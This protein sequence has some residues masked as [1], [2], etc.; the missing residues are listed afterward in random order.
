MAVLSKQE[1]TD[2][3]GSKFA[4]NTIQDITEAVL[5]E[6]RQDIADSFADVSAL[7][8][9]TAPDY[10]A[11]AIYGR[12]SLV[13]FGLPKR[14]YQ[15]K[16]PGLLPA[17]T[18]GQ[19]TT[20]WLPVAAP[21]SPLLPYRE[22]PVRQ[23]QDYSS[24]GLL[25]PSK[26]YRFT[27]RVDANGDALDDVLVVALSRHKVNEADA[28]TIGIDP[29]TRQEYLVPVAYEL[30]TDTTAPRA[31]GGYTEAQ[32]DDLLNT[33]GSAQVQAQHTQLLTTLAARAANLYAH[34]ADNTVAPFADLDSFL[35]AAGLHGGTLRL[36]G[37]ATSLYISANNRGGWP[38]Y[39]DAAG[40]TIVVPDR[41]TLR[42]S[43]AG[44][45]NLSFAN[46]YLAG[47]AN[48]TGIFNLTGQLPQTTSAGQASLLFNGQS[49]ITVNNDNNVVVLDG[50]TYKKI[51]G[52]GKYYLLGSVEV[53]DQ[54]EASNV[55]DLRG[56]TGGGGTGTVKTVNGV[57]PDAAGEVTLASR[58]SYATLPYAFATTLDLAGATA[59]LLTLT[60]NVSLSSANRQQG[61]QVR[62]FLYNSSASG[63]SLAFPST[64]NFLG[65]KPT[66]LPAGKRAVLTLECVFGGAEMDIVAGYAAQN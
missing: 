11:S 23:G 6:F 13:L 50:G 2:K 4:E 59:Q 37:E 44:L 43:A 14:F 25:E 10:D 33:K 30:A 53:A 47:G 3:W 57:A 29:Q 26:L 63:A 20:E 51:T 27:D 22:M 16:V 36:E 8:A 54:T 15:A 35:A 49:L 31:A 58:D 21:L 38:A 7:R 61:R 64:W 42:S 18:P 9:P 17:P 62:L 32:V 48:G 12:G 40:S 56:G 1:F 5:R 41:L 34:Y 65:T 39:W 52:A 55:V 24:D 60:G 66:V 45:A 19:E 28:Y 46:F